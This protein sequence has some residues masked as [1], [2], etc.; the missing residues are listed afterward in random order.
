MS[1][2]GEILI[3]S[4]DRIEGYGAN[5]LFVSFKSSYI[6]LPI[7]L[8]WNGLD[9]FINNILIKSTYNRW[10][11]ININYDIKLPCMLANLKNYL[12]GKH[13]SLNIWTPV[14]EMFFTTVKFV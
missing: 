14:C 3:L 5:D 1:A 11:I 8:L 12:L 6:C 7:H 2:D 4:V 10:L 9:M 13:I